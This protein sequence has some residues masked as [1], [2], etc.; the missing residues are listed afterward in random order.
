MLRITCP[1]R[2]GNFMARLIINPGSSAS[3]EIQLKPGAN[4]LGRGPANDFQISHDSVSGI[5][6]QI[7]LE[8]GRATIRD[9]GSTN[10]TFVNHEPVTEVTLQSAQTVSLGSVDM[11]FY[12]D[13]P[14]VRRVGES[15]AQPPPPIPIR[16]VAPQAAPA[17]SAA[18]EFCKFHP[19]TASRFYCPSCGQSFCELCVN[20]HAV[21]GAMKKFCRACGAECTPLRVRAPSPEIR[22]SFAR[23]VPGAFL[24]PLSGDGVVLLVTGTIFLSILNA[25]AFF[26]KFA[27]FY[28]WVAMAFLFVFGVGYF[29]GYL[30]RILTSSAMGE[31]KIPDWPDFTDFGTD[32]VGPFFQLL[33]TV[34]ASFLPAIVLTIMWGPQLFSDEPGL[35]PFALMGTWAF[36]CIYFP[37]A[38]LAVAMFD[39]VM[40][41]NPILILP[42]ILRVW[43]EYLLLIVLFAAVII[44]RTAVRWAAHSLLPHNLVSAL[45][46]GVFAG[47]LGLYLLIVEMRILGLLYR[48]KKSEL[49]W[50][51]R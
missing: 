17:P 38:F 24:Y 20:S 14:V 39:S 6:C 31:S 26:A 42:S 13:A 9:L 2:Q 37:M 10:G 25:A 47:S 34:L 30:R 22:P 48:S 41:V 40:A 7:V 28:G 29:T 36:G 15:V 50:F 18:P 4:S 12:S 23:L 21:G 51:N 16:I 11:V 33:G 43:K 46:I 1:A 32:V 27:L 19:K 3:W 5:H 8:A 49:G 35:A 44:L 45:L